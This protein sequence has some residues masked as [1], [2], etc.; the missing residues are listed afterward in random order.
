MVEALGAGIE[1]L[2]EG[3][4]IFAASP[5]TSHSVFRPSRCF[6]MKLGDGIS[7]EQAV[8]IRMSLITLAALCRADIRAGEWLGVGGL[9]A[10]TQPVFSRYLTIQGAGS[11]ICL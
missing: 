1:G 11:G 9:G 4:R 10:I 5:H 7:D 3:D 2:A 6:C 8:F